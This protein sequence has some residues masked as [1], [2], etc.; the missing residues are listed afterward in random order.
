[1]SEG[2][3]ESK[4]LHK[5]AQTDFYE[6]QEEKNTNAY[7]RK[8]IRFSGKTRTELNQTDNLR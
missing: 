3:G 8:K 1:M 2:V 6:N 4:A 7:N 5:V